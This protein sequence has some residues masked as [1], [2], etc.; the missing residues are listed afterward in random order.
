MFVYPIFTSYF[1]MN[2]D[3]K[4]VKHGGKCK[5]DVRKVFVDDRKISDSKPWA[6]QR[7]KEKKN[8]Y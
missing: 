6:I 2:D 8:K 1:E 3:P 4:L 7:E 5:L